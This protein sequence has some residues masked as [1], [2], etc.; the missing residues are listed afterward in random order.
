M[1]ILGIDPGLAIVGY[2]ALEVDGRGRME[3]I[4][5]GTV[6][7]YPKDRLP[8]RL[9][10]VAQGMRILTERFQPDCVA[11]EELFFARNVTTGID[12]AQARGA[13]LLAAAE[14]TDQL[15]EYTPLQV[16]QA[17]T[18]YGKADK[19]QVQQMVK[20]LLHLDAVPRPDDAADG[21]AVAVCHANMQGLR[22]LHAAM[23][24]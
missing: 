12:V 1:R 13:A 16:K 6:L 8:V 17:V 2:G 14:Y 21:V 9:V 5:Y 22:G 7:T 10:Q 3:L 15:F 23:I 11:F 20:S 4:D 19:H 18:G 24:H